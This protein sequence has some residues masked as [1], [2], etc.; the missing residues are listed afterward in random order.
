MPVFEEAHKPDMSQVKNKAPITVPVVDADD[1]KSDMPETP[2]PDHEDNHRSQGP[3]DSANSVQ[4]NFEMPVS[5]KDTEDPK[6]MVTPHTSLAPGSLNKPMAAA[7]T[8][9]SDDSQRSSSSTTSPD[10]E[11]QTGHNEMY[12]PV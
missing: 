10:D 2:E 9:D 6:S 3:D 5:I 4:S 7:S 1:E 8:D 11:S 12:L